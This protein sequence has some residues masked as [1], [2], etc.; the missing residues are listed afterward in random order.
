[1]ISPAGPVL[2]L[3]LWHPPT[4]SQSLPILETSGIPG[5]RTNFPRLVNFLQ[6]FPV[7]SLKDSGGHTTLTTHLDCHTHISEVYSE[8]PT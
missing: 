5:R 3:Q 8:V 7:A 1:M 2:L 6:A 4:N